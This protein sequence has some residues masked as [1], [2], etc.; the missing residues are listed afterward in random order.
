MT[1]LS[2]LMPVFNERA[3][4]E[5]AIERALAAELPF[6]EVEV[7]VVD[8]RSTD[9]TRE[10]LTGREWPANVS[11]HLHE[12]NLGKG[13]ALRTAL[14]NASGRLSVVL[15]AD[16]EYDPRDLGRVLEPLLSGR[17]QA[18]F[19]SRGF[20]SHS[21]YGFWY[22]M[23]NKAVTL[24]TNVLY[25][26]WISDLMTCLK[27]METDRFRSL[28]LSENGFGVEP[29]ITA[30]LLRSGVRIYEVPVTY[31]ARTR[32]EGKKLH[33]KDAL[34]VLGTLLRCRFG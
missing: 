20:E 21:A 32:E 1:D 34:V 33:A 4:I 22:V 19:G 3:T 7:V 17:A 25:N 5:R 6:D 15:D 9:G 30:R 11:L 27:A 16:L 8:D 13:G 2:V 10:V 14:A 12:R 23:G 18:V 24:A 28:G 26:S 31:S 29:E